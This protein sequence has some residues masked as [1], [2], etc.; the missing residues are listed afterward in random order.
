MSDAL[1][2]AVSDADSEAELDSVLS[3]VGDD[4]D[5][6]AVHAATKTT[7][8]TLT[9]ENLVHVMISIKN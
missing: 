2:V 5:D 4:V 8:I 7:R 1:I 6:R 9:H 3:L